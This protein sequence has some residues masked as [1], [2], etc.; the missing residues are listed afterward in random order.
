MFPAMRPPYQEASILARA[1]FALTTIVTVVFAQAAAETS[2]ISQVLDQNAAAAL[3]DLEAKHNVTVS[4]VRQLLTQVDSMIEGMQKAAT[5][6]PDDVETRELL[7]SLQ[8][9][10]QSIAQ[11]LSVLEKSGPRHLQEELRR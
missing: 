11:M 5:A 2:A 9:R 4:A 3:A 1:T 6:D 8:K 10:R 7:D